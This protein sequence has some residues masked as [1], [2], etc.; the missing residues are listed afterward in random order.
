MPAPGVTLSHVSHPVPAKPQVP[1]ARSSASFTPSILRRRSFK[2]SGFRLCVLADVVTNSRFRNVHFIKALKTFWT[3][4]SFSYDF[5]DDGTK[6]PSCSRSSLPSTDSDRSACL[7][8]WV[9]CPGNFLLFPS[10]FLFFS[11]SKIFFSSSLST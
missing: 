2:F 4:E 8:R 5:F 1:C 10:D 11:S 3:G 6:S 7:P 9:I